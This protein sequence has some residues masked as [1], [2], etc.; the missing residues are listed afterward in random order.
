[1]SDIP[2]G[3]D[4]SREPTDGELDA[5]A[6]DSAETAAADDQPVALSGMEGRVE[7][8]DLNDEIQRS[9]L[10]YAMSVIVG[11]A[12]PDVR[13][14]LKPVHRRV[15]YTMY[16]GG[17]R[18]DR[19]WN[20]CSRVVGDVMG[21]YHP[22]GDTAIYD[23]LV[24][25]AQPWVMRHKLVQ[26]Q[27]NFGSPGNDGAA[28]MRY[29][30]CRMDPLAMEMVRDIDQDTVDFQPNYDNKDVEPVVLPARFPNLLVNGSTGIAVGMAT[31]IPTHNLREV[32]DAVQWVLAHPE[33]S[34]EEILEACIERI[35]GPDFPNGALIVGR[36]GIE[37]AYRTGRGSVI[38]RAVITI[39]EDAKGRTQL[40][41]TE[42]PHQCNPDNLAMKIAELVN[43]GKLTGIA[44]VRDDSSARTG[45]R[46]CI[47]LKRDAQPRVVM[48]NLYKHTQLQDTF[49][50][51]MLALVDS[52][53]RTLRL[54]QF[55]TYWIKHQI[56]V[57][58]R[59]TA[60]RLADAEARA[61]VLRGLVKALDRLDEVIALIRSSRTTDEASERLQK[62]LDIDEVQAKAI[63][64]MQLRRLAALERQK[65]VDQLAEF[66]RLI[67]DYTDIL[68]NPTRQRQIV[69][70]EVQEITDKYGDE[71]RTKI[72]SAD[73]DLS[74]EDL[75]PDEDMVVTITRGGYAKRTRSDQYRVQRR[76]GKG[77]RGATLRADDEVDHLFT[78]SSH[79]WLLF[80]TNL[81]R[82]YRLKVWQLPEAGRDA[83][84]GHVAGLLSFL[85]DER[86]AQVLTIRTYA[87]EP[88]LLLATRRG[89]VKKTE[90]T[91]YDS[92]RQAGL[93]A[94]NFRED[95]DE[96]IGAITCNASDHVLL[97]SR[98][99]QA[100]RFQASDSEL[101]P[102]GR[103]TSGVTGMKFRSD[104]ELLSM[105]IVQRAVDEDSQFVFTVT[106]GGF[107]KRTAVSEYRVQGRG[108]LG[109]KAMK[110]NE[111]RGSLV[112]GLVVRAE[113]EIIAIKT[114]GQII[115]SAV[116]GVPAKGRDTMGV[117]FVGLKPDD[118]VAVIA[119]YPESKVDDEAAAEAGD[120][121]DSLAHAEAVDVEAIAE[122]A[123]DVSAAA[124]ASDS[125]EEK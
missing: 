27:G 123:S 9:Y 44:D 122:E 56:Q 66:E 85:P 36:K 46:L 16:D 97:I 4:A 73:G 86:I 89:L 72:I 54:D 76:G 116:A 21:K 47:V 65:I 2:Q 19:G 63:L 108:G 59:R 88:Y 31:N 99:G 114:S 95:D 103:A 43:A 28:A 30:E 121:D 35:K 69:A 6:S 12:L 101:R 53:P 117:K 87:D 40:V 24:R 74:D 45:Q 106:D 91:A 115:R 32:N 125:E 39:E 42:L 104:D 5:A 107:A 33:A 25:L 111:D 67:A 41:V 58:Q 109:I 105:A 3:P 22:H 26:G 84:G 96:L 37:D 70:D 49:G 90:L 38:M 80:F 51:N 92:P 50:C 1:M 61:H 13:D 11:R 52:V 82:V 81:G 18:P 102:M 34:K 100:I 77:V 79:H 124:E 110:L 118:A 112:G 8:I 64:D 83:K 62:L 48:N 113:D 60:Y 93:I 68:A 55:I 7:E 20:K 75:I 71:R 23:T 98:K 17:Y 94:I 120:G 10:D 15:I 14:G 78:T 29:T 57:I 119:L